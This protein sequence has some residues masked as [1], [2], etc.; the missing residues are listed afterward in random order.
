MRRKPHSAGRGAEEASDIAELESDYKLLIERAGG[1]VF[2]YR[3]GPT[4]GFD[5]VSHSVIG[6]TGYTPEELYADPNLGVSAGHTQDMSF[7]EAVR[8]SSGLPTPVIAHWR[9]KDGRQI[10]GE[11]N[12]VP[13]Y[14]DD[15]DIVAYK[16]IAR[17]ITE[18]KAVGGWL[19]LFRGVVEEAPDGVQIVDLDGNVIYSNRAVEEIYGFSPSELEGK[20]VTTMNADPNIADEVIFPTLKSIGRWSG[21]LEVK[22]RDGRT[23]PVWLSAALIKDDRGLPLAMMGVIRDVTEHRK[24]SDAISKSEAYFRLLSQNSSDLTT[25]MGGDGTIL[26]HSPADERVLGYKFGELLG[27]NAFDFVHPD[28]LPGVLATFKESL[29]TPGLT[30]TVEFRFRHMDGS[31]RVL[32]SIGNNCLDNPTV[33]GIIV[34]S[35]DITRRKQAEEAAERERRRLEQLVD[36]SPVGV[37]VVEAPSGSVSYTNREAQ[38]IA[39][40]PYQP[41]DHLT[42]YEQALVYRR[43]DGSIYKPEELPLQRALYRGENV[44]AEEVRFELPDGHSVP[45]LVDA[46]PL[47][48]LDDKI[49]GAIAII[50]DITPLE[51]IERLRNEFLGMVS[52]ELKTPLTAI[53]GAAALVLESSRTLDA[54]DTRELFG[55][56]N[57]QAD[58]LRDMMDNLLD[59]SRIEAGALSVSPEPADLRDIIDA[60]SVSFARSISDRKLLV[61]VPES[62]PLVYADQSRVVQTITNLLDNAVKFS[63][64]VT[65]IAMEVE[66]EAEQVTVRVHDQG[67][68]IPEDKLPHLF[69]KFSRVHEDKSGRLS[70]SG[71]G[72]AICKGIVEAHGGRIWVESAGVDQG[73]TFSFTLPVARGAK[74]KSTSILPAQRATHL[75]R[76]SRAGERTRI[77]AVDDDPQILRYLQRALVEKGYRFVATDDP[78]Q[79]VKL[80]ELEEPDLVLLDLK[81]PK[82]S[83]FDLLQRLREFSGVPVIILTASRGDEDAVRALGMGADDY[84]TKPFSPSELVARIEATLRRRLLSD[85]TEPKPPFVLD[86]LT[87]NFV[88]RRV[89]VADRGVS[90]TPTEYKLLYE[91]ANHAGRVLTYDQILKAVWGP[92]YSGE[93]ELLRSFIRNLRRK[94]GDEAKNPRLILTERRVGYCMHSP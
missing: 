1:V 12:L 84:I 11:V 37:F 33:R 73:S 30:P 14:D 6:L 4:P 5:Y 26:Y 81:F 27:K 74:I 46:A 67:R 10:W 31:W 70:G 44:R 80:I 18:R 75:G 92:E 66:P 51:E 78:S 58:R 23:F 13:V 76:V 68:G 63:P 60:A 42:K 90:L 40:L 35:R 94:L 39:G 15:I 69:K 86:D 48:S 71:L 87:I 47:F 93:T 25:V 55:I 57:E 34:N 85:A 82:G 19:R 72:L 3:L 8:W 77:L 62:L 89:L 54:T 64:P 9:H 59:M 79:F 50:Q 24:Q 22:H 38:R 52:H 45:T 28:D 36:M 65:S 61:H 91:L 21:E 49:I 2:H 53:K 16:G 20:H 83:G 41:D 32:E 56:I 7:F 29:N 88:E 43:P 17:D